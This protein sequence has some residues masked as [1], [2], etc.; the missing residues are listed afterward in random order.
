[1]VVHDLKVS[2]IEVLWLCLIGPG[3]W[4]GD[5]V[6]VMC[7]YFQGVD[8]MFICVDDVRFL[9]GKGVDK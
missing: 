5:Y 7:D 3:V 4:F 2:G 1:M 6:G 9:V 8:M